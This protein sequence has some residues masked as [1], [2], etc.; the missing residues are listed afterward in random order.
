M[1]REDLYFG[2]SERWTGG[3]RYRAVPSPTVFVSLAEQAQ[4]CI[5]PAVVASSNFRCF[6]ISVPCVV[7]QR[8][9]P[10]SRLRPDSGL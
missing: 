7:C 1:I 9:W 6:G 10:D 8:S 3:Y 4:V 5:C 2:V